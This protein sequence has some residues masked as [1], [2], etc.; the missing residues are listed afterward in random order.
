MARLVRLVFKARI[1]IGHHVSADRYHRISQQAISP[2]L[3]GAAVEVRKVGAR[4]ILRSLVTLLS[5]ASGTMLLLPKLVC[6]P[7]VAT[8]ASV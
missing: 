7:L 6:A 2:Q 8:P 3:S 5:F 4:G 1:H